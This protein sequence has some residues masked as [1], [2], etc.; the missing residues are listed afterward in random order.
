MAAR[1]WVVIDCWGSVARVI[2]TKSGSRSARRPEIEVNKLVAA[3]K[4][5]CA[6]RSLNAFFMAGG[7]LLAA[8]LVFGG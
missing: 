7:A 8:L 1:V 6:G 4:Q 2:G 5:S 3:P